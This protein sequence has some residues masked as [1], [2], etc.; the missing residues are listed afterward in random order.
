MVAGSLRHARESRG[1]TRDALG[2][3]VGVS[4]SAIKGLERGVRRPSIPL[5]RCLVAEL[6]DLDD[7]TKAVLLTRPKP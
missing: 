5:A 4:G 3:I 6:P 1:L 2:D 7:L